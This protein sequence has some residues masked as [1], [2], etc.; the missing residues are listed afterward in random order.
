MSPLF[1]EQLCQFIVE[2]I[3]STLCGS[4]TSRV[5]SS[6]QLERGGTQ[7]SQGVDEQ[8]PVGLQQEQSLP[9][10]FVN[11]EIAPLQ[12]SE[13][14]QSLRKEMVE[15]QHQVA[16]ETMPAEGGTPM[17]LNVVFFFTTL[18]NSAQ[19]WTKLEDNETLRAYVQRFNITV[20]EVPTAHQEVLIS[21][22]TQGLREG[23]FF[24]SLAKKP[25][26]DFLDVLKN[27]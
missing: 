14:W 20:L 26:V 23:P 12:P 10:D 11:K 6:S 9:I 24:E 17:A 22:F 21:A 19:Q 8:M 3:Y 7:G 25:T 15:L 2:T 13:I 4:G 16:K 5:G 27:T 1:C 18:M